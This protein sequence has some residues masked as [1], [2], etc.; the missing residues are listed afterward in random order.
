MMHQTSRR[1]RASISGLAGNTSVH[2]GDA[3]TPLPKIFDAQRVQNA[4][5]A[6]VQITQTFSTLAPRT[7]ATS[8]E[9]KIKVINE[10][11]RHEADDGRRAA[12]LADK[13]RWGEG[14]AYR[15]MLFTAAW[16]LGGNAQM[17][18]HT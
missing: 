5:N 13:E 10:Q 4:I 11:L 6:D 16:G 18:W 2:S 3:P 7:V 17:G 15:V 8:A 1:E 12:L 14:G 9:G